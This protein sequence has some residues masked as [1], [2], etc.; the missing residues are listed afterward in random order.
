MAAK[1]KDRVA[2]C[3]Q[4]AQK[5]DEERCNLKKESELEVRKQYMIKISNRFAALENLNDSKD[6]N[7]TWEIIKETIKI[8]AK[9][10]KVCTNGSRL[11]CS[12]ERI[13]NKV[14]EVI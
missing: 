7:R 3:K 2:V 5:L 10:S 11:N 9:E 4:G 14:T 6:I 12:S 13:Q 1:V 8:S